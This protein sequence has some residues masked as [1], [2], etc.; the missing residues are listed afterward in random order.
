MNRRKDDYKKC[1]K[2][3]CLFFHLTIAFFSFFTAPMKVFLHALLTCSASLVILALACD[4][5]MV[6]KDHIDA[7]NLV[8]RGAAFGKAIQ[9]VCNPGSGNGCNNGSS[10]RSGRSLSRLS[11]ESS[12]GSW[13]DSSHET[14]SGSEDD[15]HSTKPQDSSH[16]GNDWKKGGLVSANDGKQ[17]RRIKLL[18]PIKDNNTPDDLQKWSGTYTY[19]N[20][21]ERKTK[22]WQQKDNGLAQL[23]T[24]STPHSRMHD[25][26][27]PSSPHSQ[28]YPTD[29]MTKHANNQLKI[30]VDN[31]E[32][33][34][35]ARQRRR[36]N[37]PTRQMYYRSSSEASSFRRK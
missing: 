3:C 24:G 12:H 6:S 35:N 13:S 36:N 8:K 34:R 16:H 22:L 10:R 31:G 11:S 14:S 18:K 4:G 15:Q 9:E 2:E 17:N 5:A 27:N 30:Y 21:K 19:K 28:D 32:K 37:A 29:P 26:L 23:A 33:R 20:G 7:V 25:P 1:K